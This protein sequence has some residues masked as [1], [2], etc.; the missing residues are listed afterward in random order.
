MSK[1]SHRSRRGGGKVN[2]KREKN[3]EKL[4]IIYTI[5]ERVLKM[6]LRHETS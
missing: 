1:T 6:E 3:I 4:K 5:G 2:K